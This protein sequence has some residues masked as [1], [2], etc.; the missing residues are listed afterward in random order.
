MWRLHLLFYIFLRLLTFI[1]PFRCYFLP[2]QDPASLNRYSRLILFFPADIYSL[3]L[4]SSV[5]RKAF[6]KR[7]RY[8]RWTS[9][10]P[11]CSDMRKKRSRACSTLEVPFEGRPVGNGVKLHIRL[12]CVIHWSLGTSTWYL[13][14]HQ[15][16]LKKY[17]SVTLKVNCFQCVRY[18]CSF[19][20][21]CIWL[22]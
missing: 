22:D 5:K 8:H 19:P 9:L 2:K 21:S 3:L 7:T 18:I 12:I 11:P 6:W 17:A 4:H 14:R 15:N 10:K 20:P 1:F 13:P 16:Q